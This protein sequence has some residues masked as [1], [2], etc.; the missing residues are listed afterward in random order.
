MIPGWGAEIPHNV[1]CGKKKKKKSELLGM[2]TVFISH[3]N[4]IFGK[5]PI[6]L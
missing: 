1:Q 6:E 5:P 2:E 3:P 4:K